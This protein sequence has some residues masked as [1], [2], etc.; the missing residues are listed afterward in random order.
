[1]KKVPALLPLSKSEEVCKVLLTV[2]FGYIFCFLFLMDYTNPEMNIFYRWS[3]T[4]QSALRHPILFAI[5][6]MLMLISFLVN[7]DYL[8]RRY[9]VSSKIVAVLQYLGS[10]GMLVTLFVKTSQEKD[11]KGI[12]MYEV[13]QKAAIVFGAA[14]AFC[15]FGVILLLYKK[16]KRFLPFVIGG[17]IFI[18]TVIPAFIFK[19]CGFVE[20]A[21]TMIAMVVLYFLN[22]SP[23]P[24]RWIG[25]ANGSAAKPKAEKKK[26]K[27]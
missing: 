5:Y 1:M 23:K 11:L 13:H 19:L 3:T 4:S 15:L 18:V 2:T 10:L 25:E 21:P 12:V 22:F 17:I 6:G 27:A 20:T 16:S 7:L 8:R 14:S 26:V 9:E 24:L